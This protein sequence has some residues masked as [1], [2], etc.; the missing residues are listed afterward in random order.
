MCYFVMVLWFLYKRL[1]F[2][3]VQEFVFGYSDSELWVSA[4]ITLA[5][6][7]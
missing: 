3:V 5:R 6:W 7:S 2:C 1:A 4:D